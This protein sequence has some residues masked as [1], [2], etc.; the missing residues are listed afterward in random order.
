MN[1]AASYLFFPKKGPVLSHGPGINSAY[2]FN[3]QWKNIDY[4]T[5]I[6]YTFTFRNGAVFAGIFQS[7]YVYLTAPFDPTNSG[8]DTLA[9]GTEHYANTTGFDF[10]STPKKKFTFSLNS[11]VGGYYANGHRFTMGGEINYRFQPKRC[12]CLQYSIACFRPNL[13]S[14]HRAPRARRSCPSPAGPM[15]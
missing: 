3:E 15:T 10:V 1:P 11:R 4:H 2:Y 6:P 8:K 9:R 7:D 5:S 14:F 13:L 12:F